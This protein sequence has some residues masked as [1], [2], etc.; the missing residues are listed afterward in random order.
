LQVRL[1][2]PVLVTL[3]VPSQ[4]M[5]HVPALHPTFDPAPT[6]CVHE[7]PVQVTLQAAPQLPE[8]VAVGPQSRLQPLVE[9]VQP[10]NAQVWPVGHAQLVPTQTVGPQAVIASASETRIHFIIG[11]PL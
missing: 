7:V 6:V 4:V 9:A 1:S 11:A 5:L 2:V 3:Q 8:Q 10:S